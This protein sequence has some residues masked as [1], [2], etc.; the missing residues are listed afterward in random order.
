MVQQAVFGGFALSNCCQSLRV[1][2]TNDLS[3][4]LDQSVVFTELS[5]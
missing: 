1:Y 2:A 3:C 5:L 4:T